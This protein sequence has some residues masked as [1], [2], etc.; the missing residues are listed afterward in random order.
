MSIVE[1]LEDAVE[2]K[3][4]KFVRQGVTYDLK[5][6]VR[7]KKGEDDMELTRVPCSG[8]AYDDK[9][10]PVSG[11]KPVARKGA[12][13]G[14][15]AKKDVPAKKGSKRK[16]AAST[17][18]DGMSCRFVFPLGRV[19]THTGDGLRFTRP[20]G[21]HVLPPAISAPRRVRNTRLGGGRFA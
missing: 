2:R 14:D 15:A 20:E 13:A 11:L 17:A 7:K 16:N 10:K 9:H 8:K 12:D 4:A 5:N 19:N 6:M 1:L 18:S 21:G 3:K